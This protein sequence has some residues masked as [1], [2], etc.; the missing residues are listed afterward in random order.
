MRPMNI[1]SIIVLSPFTPYT[2]KS[3]GKRVKE[4]TRK[5]GTRSRKCQTGLTCGLCRSFCCLGSL[6]PHLGVR[7][8]G[9]QAWPM[10]VHGVRRTGARL[11]V[12]SR[13]RDAHQK[14]CGGEGQAVAPRCGRHGTMSGGAGLA[15]QATRPATGAAGAGKEGSRTKESRPGTKGGTEATALRQT[16]RR[17]GPTGCERPRRHRSR[18][19][20]GSPRAGEWARR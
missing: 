3:T 2:R 16:P 14:T 11:P 1:K 7:W 12:L 10:Q 13:R 18:W 5:R 19:P 9:Q 15:A 8:G 20:A 4:R 17:G 6:F